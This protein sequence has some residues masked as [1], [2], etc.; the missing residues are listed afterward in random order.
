MTCGP[1]SVGRTLAANHT[2]DSR[3]RL[4]DVR[5]IRANPE[6]EAKTVAAAIAVHVGFGKLCLNLACT[7]RPIGKK[8][9]VLGLSA[10]WRNQICKPQSLSSAS[11]SCA[12]G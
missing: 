5:C 9:A 4:I 7:P 11:S 1:L 6:P 2:P 3:Q 12:A 8:I 10:P